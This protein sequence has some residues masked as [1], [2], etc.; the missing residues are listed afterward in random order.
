MIRLSKEAILQ[1][2]RMAELVEMLLHLANNDIDLAHQ[3]DDETLI[4]ERQ[5]VLEEI[6]RLHTAVSALGV[7]GVDTDSARWLEARVEFE[8]AQQDDD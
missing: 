2:S 3:P 7:T 8:R 5:V 6:D 4:E 1:A